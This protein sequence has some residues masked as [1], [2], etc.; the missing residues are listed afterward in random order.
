[1]I[2]YNL[3]TAQITRLQA[4]MPN[5]YIQALAYDDRRDMLYCLCFPPEKLLA[6]H[7]SSGEVKDLGLI[8]SGIGGMTQGENLIV[9]DEGCVWCNWSV[10]RAWQS[11]PG[12]DMNRIF[13]YDPRN[14]TRTF[15]KTGLP[16][17]DRNHGTIKAEAWFNFSDGSVYASGANGSLFRIDRTTGEA[18]F[19]FTPTNDRPSRL[20]SLVKTEEGVAY[21]VTGRDGKC[22]LMKV[23]YLNGTFEKLGEIRDQNGIP[24]WQCHHMIAADKGVFFICENDNPYRSSYLWEVCL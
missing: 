11:T 14:E 5:V 22:E 17:P 21:G 9:D 12:V 4:P 10:T 13:R 18:K 23:N 8:G 20:T 2:R 6:V 1:L 16:R 19:L 3:Q 7:L 15:F 24:L